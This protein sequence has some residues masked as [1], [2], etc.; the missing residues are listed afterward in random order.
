MAPSRGKGKSRTA[1]S[2][3]GPSRSSAR[4]SRKRNDATPDVFQ[5]MLAEAAVTDPEELSDR[6]LKRRKVATNVAVPDRKAVQDGKATRARDA[7]EARPVKSGGK[8][9][10]TKQQTIQ[11]SSDDDDDESEFDFEDVDLSRPDAATSG[12]ENDAI[13]DVSVSLAQHTTPKRQAKAKRKGGSTADKAHRLIAHK[14]HVPVS[15]THL[16]LPTKRIV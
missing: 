7:E 15:Y 6:P 2:N 10:H 16:T 8:A 13:Q 1:L 14:A 11:E 4:S 3:A 5:D 9:P 12:S